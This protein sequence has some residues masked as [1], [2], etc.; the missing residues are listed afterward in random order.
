MTD[1]EA[2]EALQGGD[3]SG[4]DALVAGHQRRALQVAYQITRDRLAAEDIVADAFLTVY[5]RV[6]HQDPARPF[7]PWLLRIVI[8]RAISVTR[9]AER[10]RRFAHLLRPRERSE[11]PEETAERREEQREVMRALAALP[12]NER[13]ALSLR[14][15]L[16]LDERAIANLLDWP[17][18]TVKTRL[19]RGR[20]RLRQ[21][22]VAAESDAGP[23][24]AIG[25]EL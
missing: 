8:N 17:L 4:M 16:D 2:M 3:A 20:D 15:L 24:C 6:Q 19:R 7:E 5:E 22:L 12:A 11:G 18:G 21:Q 23:A 1:R 13:A 25:A 9:R 10:F 14:Y